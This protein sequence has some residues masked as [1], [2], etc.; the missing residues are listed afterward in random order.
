MSIH[1]ETWDRPIC[2]FCKKE[3]PYGEKRQHRHGS[4][5]AAKP[6]VYKLKLN[7]EIQDDDSIDAYIWNGHFLSIQNNGEDFF[8]IEHYDRHGNELGGICGAETIEAAKIEA[9]NWL[10]EQLKLFMVQE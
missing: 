5:L 2:E 9:E 10:D 4:C 7:W 8:N 1:D 6:K 3:I